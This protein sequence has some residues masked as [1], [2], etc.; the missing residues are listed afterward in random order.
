M[1]HPSLSPG[2]ARVQR[3][4]LLVFV[5]SWVS[6]IFL[7]AAAATSGGDWWVGVGL[8][9][10]V[11][12]A[13]VWISFSLVPN[14]ARMRA[15]VEKSKITYAGCMVC[16]AWRPDRCFSTIPRPT[17]GLESHFPALHTNVRFCSDSESCR[18]VAIDA[19]AWRGKAG[20]GYD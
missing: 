10:A 13:C 12:M 19:G 3:I 15:L 20:V 1:S 4:A 5:V 9:A 11:I 8:Q 14:H 6:F 16:G 18:A 2:E 7:V 17:L